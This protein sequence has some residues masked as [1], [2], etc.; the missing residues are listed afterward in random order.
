MDDAL[1]DAA[2]GRSERHRL[3]VRYLWTRDGP[4]CFY[5]GCAL[6]EDDAR[7]DHFIPRSAGGPD[8][9][10]NRRVACRPCDVAKGDMVPDGTNFRPQRARAKARAEAKAGRMNP[11]A[12]ESRLTV[13]LGE[14]WPIEAWREDVSDPLSRMKP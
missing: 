12:R 7:L 1:V 3:K 6:A 8:A 14:V 11:R 2:E 10:E 13:S 9:L 5:C 4:G